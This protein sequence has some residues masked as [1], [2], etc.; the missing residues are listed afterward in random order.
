M[1]RREWL[2]N[3]LLGGAVALLASC[4]GDEDEE[5][6]PDAEP[7]PRTGNVVAAAKEP[8]ALRLAW[9]EHPNAVN[10]PKPSILGREALR[11]WNDGSIPGRPDESTLEH[12]PIPLKRD[13]NQRIQ[14]SISVMDFL[15]AGAAG[16]VAAADV[17]WLPR[18]ADIFF[19]I[20]T[21]LFTPLDRW[22]QAD[23]RAPLDAFGEE[24]LRLVRINGRTLGL[25]LAV[26][27]GVLGYNA[28]RFQGAS[29]PPAASA[30]TWQEFIDAG[31][32]LTQDVDGDGALDQWGFAANW[33]FPDW[34]PLLLQ[35]G[36]EVVD[37]DTGRIEMD[38]PASARAL[39]AWDEFGRVHGIHPYGPEVSGDDLRGW[40][41]AQQSGM[42]FSRFVK[43]AWH[44]WPDFAPMPRGPQTTTPLGLEEALAVPAAAAEDSAYAA[45][46]PL[47]HWI[48]ERRVLPA[49][50]AGWQYIENPDTDHFDLIFPEANQEVAVYALENAK[51]SYAAS[52]SAIS[53][54][55]F[56]QVTL[57]LARGEVG[58]EQAIDQA[59]A[60]LQSYVT[61]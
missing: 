19:L 18:Y 9:L 39:T 42:R 27:P 35:E 10:P 26:A 3:M 38:A 52:S 44:Y 13:E 21:E 45:L 17:V 49:V 11:G 55:L 16:G 4:G 47:A 5:P 1:T 33:D 61:E 22:L 7:T 60:W 8:Q 15:A 23:K 6:P 32:Q 41:D 24:A 50:T 20:Q 12:T 36:G 43:Q 56:Q 29:V 54:H 53:Y 51:A 2:G 46:V 14:L 57:P 25:P 28:D 40:G 59:V 48:G 30:W 58:V 31:K 34:L 37:L